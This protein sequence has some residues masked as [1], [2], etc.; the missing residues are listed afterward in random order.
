[1]SA[2]LLD[3]SKIKQSFAAASGTY[4][5]V[6]ELQRIVG[7]E[8]LQ[9]AGTESST[10]T[11]L[12]LGCGT[13]FLTEQLLASHPKLDKIIALDLAWTMLQT[14][15]YKLSTPCPERNRQKVNYVCA[16]AERLPFAEQSLDGVFSNL[17]LQWCNHFEET[18]TGVK[19]ILKP[20]SP[21]VFST[22]G[23]ATLRE[24]KSAW[25]EADD[26]SHVNEFYR[27]GQVGQF[28][29][30]A[31]FSGIQIT[32]KFHVSRYASVKA[33]MQE[34][35]QIGAHNVSSRRNKKFTTKTQ[36]QN[37]I[38][39]YERHRSGDLIPATFEVLNVI[40]RA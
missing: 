14:S 8:L 40:A 5:G 31:G 6:A 18:L 23:P 32:G 36:M 16:D 30:Q 33:L 24:L 39:A 22:F 35:K 3:K 9:H 2:V 12:D 1:M 20:G 37:M 17:A 25:A 10:G 19:R 13:G 7:K 15:R 26:Y 11:I 27:E 38:A 34:L 21:L 29:E 4:D 28:L